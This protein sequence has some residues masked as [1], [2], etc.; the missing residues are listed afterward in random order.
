[1]LTQFW[2]WRKTVQSTLGFET[3]DKAAALGLE[4]A[5][6]LTD[7]RQYIN[8]NLGFRN[9]KIWLLYSKIA[10]VVVAKPSGNKNKTRLARPV[11]T[12]LLYPD[13]CF[14][15]RA[16]FRNLDPSDGGWFLNP[17][18]T[19]L[20]WIIEKWTWLNLIISPNQ[21]T[22]LKFSKFSKILIKSPLIWH[23]VGLNRPNIGRKFCI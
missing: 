8:S 22:R 14:S 2:T 23:M 19:V 13:P 10:A 4:T 16:G 17:M 11:T 21:S 15:G 7:P 18:L 20:R 6:P 9:L 1:M 3:L 5:T 12:W